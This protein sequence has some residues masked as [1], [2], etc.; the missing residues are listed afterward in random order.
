MKRSRTLLLRANISICSRAL[1]DRLREQS[2]TELPSQGVVTNKLDPSQ[3]APKGL[4]SF[5]CP[6]GTK[7]VE[8][9]N[10]EELFGTPS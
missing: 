1:A 6:R 3:I 4:T 2:G 7:S 9:R 8:L 5:A 10:I